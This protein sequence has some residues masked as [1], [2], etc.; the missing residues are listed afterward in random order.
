MNPTVEKTNFLGYAAITAQNGE[1]EFTLVPDLGSNLISIRHL[2]TNTPLLHTPQSMTQYQENP[3]LWGTPVLFPPNRLEDGKL[4]FEGTTYQFDLN[5]PKLHNHIHG[6]V[7]SKPWRVV[8]TQVENGVAVV[9]TEID[10]RE[11]PDI[12]R[13]FPHPFV[14]RMRVTLDANSID[15]GMSVHN[16]GQSAFPYGLGYHTTFL[17]PF[18]VGGELGHCRMK[19]GT[20]K[21]WEL[22][23]RNLPTGRLLDSADLASFREGLNLTGKPLDDA[24]MS[25]VVDGGTNECV[26]T[27]VDA[28]L[29]VVY[30]ADKSF[31]H[32]VVYNADSKKGFVCP[33]PYTWVTNAPNLDLPATTT[34]VRV[35]APGESEEFWTKIQVSTL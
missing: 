20:K 17:F 22:N 10:A 16:V 11:F 12:T 32:W 3:V 24:F 5:E 18:R 9:E 6:L 19:L 4:R 31:L 33:E 14:L 21:R 29:Q 13:Q 35:M 1:L 25:D 7:N 28:N 23:E 26:L 8:L 30:Q 2:P 34:G 15:L 27:D